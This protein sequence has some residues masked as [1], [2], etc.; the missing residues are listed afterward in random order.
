MGDNAIVTARD[1][2]RNGSW[3]S[4]P[5][6]M[7]VWGI[8]DLHLSLAR[9]ERRERFAARWRDHAEHVE[10]EWR[11][12]VKHSDLVL[13]PGDISMARNHRDL[14]PDLA[15]L[16]RLP[17]TKVIAPGNHDTWW[18]GVDKVRPM[19]RRSLLAVCGDAISVLGTVVCG[20]GGARRCP[21]WGAIPLAMIRVRSPRNLPFS[22][23][24]LPAP[25]SKSQE[26]ERFPSV[27]PWHFGAS[28]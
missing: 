15:W 10:R 25:P 20:T 8:S 28:V 11:A 17:G 14:Q 19:L 26:K 1:N 24:P 5:T 18:N 12:V 27:L 7:T 13:L 6:S 4:S 2:G 22:T 23:R 3:R 21:P 9:P 16:D